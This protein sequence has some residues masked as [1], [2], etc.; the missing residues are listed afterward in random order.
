MPRFPARSLLISRADYIWLTFGAKHYVCADGVAS[1]V[2]AL[3]SP[4]SQS[5]IHLGLSG[6]VSRLERSDKRWRLFSATGD[7]TVV[8]SIIFATQA[9][10]ALTL[11]STCSP[12]RERDEALAAFEYCSTVVV[13]HFDTHRVL[14][15]SHSDLR[16]LNIMLDV[17]TSPVTYPARKGDGTPPPY[18]AVPAA[19]DGDHIMATHV[20][21]RTHPD[22]ATS[23]PH[24][25]LA[26]KG[27]EV[28]LLQTTNPTVVIDRSKLVSE[29]W[30][31]RAKVTTGSR[32]ALDGFLL[33][34]TGPHRG[35]FQG[36][37]GIWFCGSWAA[38]G[39]PL[40]EGCVVSAEAVAHALRTEARP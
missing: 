25:A 6:T 1:V 31:E 30:F 33:P 9:N 32:R 13:N 23:T 16:D 7:E 22:L 12:D 4:L 27:S 37:D 38:V 14:P 40:L 11:L 21:T 35:R 15:S 24:L 10:H 2:D 26:E 17:P 3:T 39:I 34:R 28:T 36:Q 8:D 29:T 5:S 20:L 19:K 18:E